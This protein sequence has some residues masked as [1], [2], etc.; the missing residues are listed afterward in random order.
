VRGNGSDGAVDVVVV[1]PFHAGRLRTV[2]DL[3]RHLTRTLS[4]R[5]SPLR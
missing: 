3:E 4:G 2:T 5:S 1:D